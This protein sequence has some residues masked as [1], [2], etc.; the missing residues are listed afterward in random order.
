[1]EDTYQSFDGSTREDVLK[2][3]AEFGCENNLTQTQND[4]PT[5]QKFLDLTDDYP[6]ITYIGYIIKKPRDDFRVSIEGFVINDLTAPQA[7][8]IFSKYRNADECDYWTNVNT[9]DETRTYGI[10]A[11]WD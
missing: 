10:R 11:W 7:L 8:E 6:N 9:K 3:I 1:M 4:S 5:V 2:F